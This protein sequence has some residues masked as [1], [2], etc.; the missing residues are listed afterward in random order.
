MIYSVTLSAVQAASRQMAG[1]L[2][3]NELER[4]WKEYNDLIHCIVFS[5]EGPKK[6]TKA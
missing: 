4:M 2:V 6:T 1:R 5:L 3:N